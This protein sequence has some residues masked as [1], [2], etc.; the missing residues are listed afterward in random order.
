MKK[1]FCKG[2]LVVAIACAGLTFAGCGCQSGP[3]G[4]YQDSTGAITAEF[5]AGGK[6]T[7]TIMG[8][9]I[10]GTYAVSGNNVTITGPD[11]QTIVLTMNGDGSLDGPTGTPIGKLTKSK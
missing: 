2:L 11:K 5:V 9:P 3:S 8:L 7:L 1:H 10:Q 4:K 6:V